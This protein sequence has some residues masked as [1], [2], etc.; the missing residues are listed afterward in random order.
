MDEDWPQASQPVGRQQF[1]GTR[2]LQAQEDPRIGLATVGDAVDKKKYAGEYYQALE[3]HARPEQEWYEEDQRNLHRL[4][5]IRGFLCGLR[6]LSLRDIVMIN[7]GLPPI[8]PGEFLVET[9]HELA[10]ID[11]RHSSRAS[12]A[13]P[14][15][16]MKIEAMGRRKSVCNS[17]GEN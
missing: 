14:T 8:H 5:E 15:V 3:E 12:L 9:L 4:I 16:P 11:C 13:Y 17:G 10:G 1:A 7:S 2:L 6:R